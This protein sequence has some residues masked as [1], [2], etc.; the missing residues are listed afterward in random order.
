MLSSLNL[1]QGYVED[2]LNL[3]M[4]KAQKFNINY[5]D[6]SLFKVT[7]FIKQTFDLKVKAKDINLSF[8]FTDRL[9]LPKVQDDE[10]LDGCESLREELAVDE[11]HANQVALSN[12]DYPVLNGDKRRLKQVLLNL[13]KNAL[14]FTSEGSIS[15]ALAYHFD[16][17]TL[18]GHVRDTGV[19]IA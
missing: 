11:E 3:T 8:I 14:K 6:F 18:V 17:Q 1:M 9:S 15:V 16:N 12:E 7:K 2:M 13:V 10:L 5:G 4:I 19:G